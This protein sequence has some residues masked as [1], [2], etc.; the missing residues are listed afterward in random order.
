LTRFLTTTR[1]GHCEYFASA[2]VLL[3]R[4]L[5]IPARYAVGYYVHETRGSGYVVRERDGHAWCLAWNKELKCWEDFDTTP[6]SWV[7]IEGRRTH[8]GE[9][10][11]DIKSWLKLQIAKF[12]WG[13]A[14]LQQYI[15]WMLIPVMLVL[16]Y[17]IIFRH[18]GKLK[19]TK[20][21]K[22]AMPI[23]WPGLDSEF[24]LLEMKLA[25]R[26]V[27]RQ[28]GEPLADWLERALASPALEELRVPLS[29]LL[30]LHY[31]H[32]F[33]PHG[34]STV[35]REELRRKA[36]DAMERISL[37]SSSSSSSSSY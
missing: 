8:F 23:R 32:R 21:A 16:L 37:S 5:G 6:P 2:T 34:L 4:R 10:F 27:P 24:Y 31:R 13:Q 17:H 18:R 11:A 36:T 3:L 35:E 26:G 30:R 29:E 25:A 19:A 22:P 1:S 14:N 28:P 15:F 12:R 33:D 7:A 20:E 9:W